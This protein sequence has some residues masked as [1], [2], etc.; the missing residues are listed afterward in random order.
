MKK[1]YILM[2]GLGF[3]GSAYAAGIIPGLPVQG[4]SPE[5]K[6]IKA[7]REGRLADCRTFCNMAADECH[8][9]VGQSGGLTYAKCEGNRTRCTVGCA[10]GASTFSTSQ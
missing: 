2:L 8:A 10:R 7:S 6:A 5:E 3:I 9:K 1:L 4:D